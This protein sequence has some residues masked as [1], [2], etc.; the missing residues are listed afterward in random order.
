[1]VKD[2]GRVKNISVP[3][4]NNIGDEEEEEWASDGSAGSYQGGSSLQ[5]VAS[6]STAGSGKRAKP[7]K[8]KPITIGKGKRRH[9]IRRGLLGHAHQLIDRG[10]KSALDSVPSSPP[11]TA[12]SSVRREESPA[13][14][15]WFA[16][17]DR[18][19]SGANTPLHSMLSDSGSS[20]PAYAASEDEAKARVTFDLP[21]PSSAK[22]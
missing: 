19:K 8:K 17:E 12:R 18:P 16:D 11:S 1:M 5:P 4:S 15:V 3:P 10:R 13:R 22:R 9:S 20:S 21:R 7:P 2:A 6:S 14:S